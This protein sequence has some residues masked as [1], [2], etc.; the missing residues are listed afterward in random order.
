MAYFAEYGNTGE[1]F[2][3][4]MA[5]Q[6]RIGATVKQIEDCR[7]G[8]TTSLLTWFRCIQWAS[9][10]G[11]PIPESGYQAMDRLI[12]SRKEEERLFRELFGIADNQK[13]I[14]KR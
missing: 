4:E 14:G 7:A 12:E 9:K 1:A 10:N 2:Q 6:R 13:A 3:A 11:E 5:E 8:I